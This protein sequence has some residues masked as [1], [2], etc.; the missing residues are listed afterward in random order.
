MLNIETFDN[1]R[2]GNVVYKALAHPLAAR[3]L[4]LLAGSSGRIALFDPDGIAEPL[5]A[6]CPQLEIEGIYAQDVELLGRSRAGHVIRAVIDL[7]AAPVKTV[8]LAAFDVGRQAEHL[9][10]WLPQGAKLITLDEIK[11]P[12]SW[13]SVPER[14]LDARNFATNFAFFR[15]DGH[16]ATRLTTAN[17]WAGYGA[18]EVLFQHILFSQDGEVLAEWTQKA[19]TGPG[20]YVLDSQ[21][22]RARFGLPAFTGQLFIHAIGVRG[23][24]VLKYALDT[25]AT[26]GGSSLSCTHDANAWP[27]ARFAGLPAPREGEVVRL[28]IQNSHNVA[29]PA[30]ALALDRMGASAPVALDEEVPPFATRA[31][32]IA[33]FFPDLR[34]PAQIELLAGRYVVRPRYEVVQ[35]HRT[36]IAH[37]NVERVDLQPDPGIARLNPL[38]G[39]G[40]ILPFPIL[41]RG[42]F[43]TTALPTPMAESED[44]TPLRL[45]VFSPD[46][47]M[48]AQ[49]FL[50][51]LPRGHE[52]AVDLDDMLAPDALPEGGHAELTYDFRDGGKAN[53]WLHALFRFEN[54]S[55]NHAAESSFGAH[56]F[57]TF[58]TY[59][60]EPQSYSGKPPGL[61][62]RLFLKLGFGGRKSFCIL[63]YPASAP[64]VKL[65]TTALELY[66]A[67]GVLLETAHLNIACSGSKLIRP[68]DYFAPALRLAAGEAGYILI[69][70]T[71]CRLFGFHGLEDH[72][73]GFSLDHMFGF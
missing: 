5:L 70:D 20:G 35:G 19:P 48:L 11:L 13:L 62:T 38:L 68:S 73:G 67:Q 50:G 12:E 41:P 34:W 61:S 28:W 15:D 31:L 36:R 64:W 2:G 54:R 33:T 49:K 45:D 58:M 42:L 8:L 43:K 66:D 7:P 24:D 6:L 23:H 47:E 39:R 52:C 17:Y 57:N 51:R 18:R 55:Q 21:E 44:E 3:A 14:Y 32:N 63:I 37:V 25:Y 65:S 71:T 16:F 30:G 10:S 40:Y 72:V 59:K 56:I 60:N 29:I 1:K 27:S 26:D 22:V 46:G 69:R 9:R 4:A 53:G